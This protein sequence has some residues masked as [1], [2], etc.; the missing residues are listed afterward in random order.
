MPSYPM[1]ILELPGWKSHGMCDS[2]T[3]AIPW[4]VL[5]PFDSLCPLLWW[6]VVWASPTYSTKLRRGYLKISQC[7]L[8][9]ELLG[10][11]V[12]SRSVDFSDDLNFPE[13]S[14]EISQALCHGREG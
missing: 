9:L 4:R 5:G 7:C 12:F 14:E 1:L 2:V 13:C 3:L 10:R 6:S 11:F 8:Y